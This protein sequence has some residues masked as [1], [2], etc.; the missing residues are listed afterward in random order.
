VLSSPRLPI[1]SYMMHRPS[2]TTSTCPH[3]ILTHCIRVY[4]YICVYVNVCVHVSM[5]M[6]MCMGLCGTRDMKP[7]N[8]LFG[9]DGHIVL[10]DYGIAAQLSEANPT[11]SGRAGTPGYQG[12]LTCVPVGTC[13]KVD[14]RFGVAR[15]HV[16]F[17]CHVCG[18]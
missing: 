18:D 7:E 11:T 5:C 1:T 9:V 16:L 15:Q 14:V 13:A 10:S 8:V 6:C 12:T 17:L 4:V 2:V 3:W